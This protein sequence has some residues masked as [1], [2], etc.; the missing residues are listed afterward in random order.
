LIVRGE[1]T[2]ARLLRC[3]GGAEHD[4]FPSCPGGCLGDV[5]PA[6]RQVDVLPA[7]SEEFA[8]TQAGSGGEA[9]QRPKTRLVRGLDKPD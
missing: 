9:N 5:D 3:L 7:Q 2:T 4:A 8:L 1:R 6:A